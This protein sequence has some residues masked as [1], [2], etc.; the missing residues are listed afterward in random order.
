MTVTFERVRHFCEKHDLIFDPI[1]GEPSEE[2]LTHQSLQLEQIKTDVLKRCNKISTYHLFELC[3]CGIVTIGELKCCPIQ[4]IE[5]IKKWHVEYKLQTL[6]RYLEFVSKDIHTISF[7][8]AVQTICELQKLYQRHCKNLL[9]TEEHE[10]FVCRVEVI[11]RE[12]SIRLNHEITEMLSSVYTL[13]DAINSYTILRDCSILRNLD[14][15]SHDYQ[16]YIREAED[17]LKYYSSEVILHNPRDLNQLGRFTRYFPEISNLIDTIEQYENVF[18]CLPDKSWSEYDST[19]CVYEQLLI[20]HRFIVAFPYSLFVEAIWALFDST[21]SSLDITWLKTKDIK[22]AIEHGILN[23]EHV[24]EHIN[25]CLYKLETNLGSHLWTFLDTDIR[26]PEVPPFQYCQTPDSLDVDILF[27]GGVAS[28]FVIQGLC[29]VDEDEILLLSWKASDA[30]FFEKECV[31]AGVEDSLHNCEPFCIHCDISEKNYQVSK[32][33]RIYQSS[34]WFHM[35]LD[36]LKHGKID[37]SDYEFGKQLLCNNIKIVN[38]TINKKNKRILK[39]KSILG[40]QDEELISESLDLLDSIGKGFWGKVSQIN[41]IAYGVSDYT[42][43]Q[44]EEEYARLFG[45]IYNISE[46]YFIKDVSIIPFSIGERVFYDKYIYDKTDSVFLLHH[47]LK[48]TPSRKRKSFLRKI[49][50]WT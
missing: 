29:G 38:I 44:F 13:S 8:S 23:E 7:G 39:G 30:F 14:M 41:I 47:F 6:T 22:D 20:L 19:Q 21:H 25:Q 35:I 28:E 34:L 31:A 27:L 43:S 48:G 42:A 40:M 16:L 49:L 3:L 17:M 12:L 10:Q 33:L 15:M 36:E 5:R 32:G 45:R 9:N 50:G 37:L 26:H 18:P 2:C 11:L 24:E 4:R 1:E 46:K